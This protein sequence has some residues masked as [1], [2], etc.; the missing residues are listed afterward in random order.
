VRRVAATSSYTV[1]FR[2]RP[3]AVAAQQPNGRVPRVARLLALAHRIDQMIAA[4]ELKDLAH[5]A[6]VCC[7]TRAR[8][9]Q[10]CNL[11]LLCPTI[12]EAILEMP[13]VTKGR[14]PVSERNLRGI[15]A[16]ADWKR[17]VPRW[18]GLLHARPTRTCTTDHS[19]SPASRRDS[20]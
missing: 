7:L 19:L 18:D 15:V 9:T 4:G 6:K 14:D 2:R 8:V 3:V 1:E 11:L 17:Q 10:V 5:A 12:Q 20:K 16:E 13:S